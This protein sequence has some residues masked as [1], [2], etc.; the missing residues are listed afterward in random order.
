MAIGRARALEPQLNGTEWGTAYYERVA[1]RFLT[2]SGSVFSTSQYTLDIRAGALTHGAIQGIGP[3]SYPRNAGIQLSMDG[4]ISYLWDGAC[5]LRII[6]LVLLEPAS[7]GL[8]RFFQLA[9]IHDWRVH[10]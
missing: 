6:P 7:S 9:K 3:E 2:S 8:E 1:I 10:R 4:E 5:M